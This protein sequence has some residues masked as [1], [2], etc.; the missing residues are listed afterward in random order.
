MFFSFIPFFLSIQIHF[1]IA[2]GRL[3]SFLYFFGLGH[4]HTRRRNTVREVD[5]K[6]SSLQVSFTR[7]KERGEG[8][9]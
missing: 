7:K 9:D 1:I 4:P 6:E 8:E 2:T 3:F 5:I